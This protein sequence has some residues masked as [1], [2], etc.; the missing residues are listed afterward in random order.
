MTAMN[1]EKIRDWRPA[2][3][4]EVLEGTVVSATREAI[5]IRT[6]A[7]ELVRVHTSGRR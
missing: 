5:V 6:A 2:S 1:D 3:P 7:G 4:D